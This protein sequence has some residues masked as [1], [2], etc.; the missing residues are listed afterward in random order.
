MLWLLVLIQIPEITLRKAIMRYLCE[1]H[2]VLD[3]WF[4]ESLEDPVWSRSFGPLGFGV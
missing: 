1:L 4:G 3:K 2:G